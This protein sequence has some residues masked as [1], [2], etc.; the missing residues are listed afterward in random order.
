RTMRYHIFPS[1]TLFRSVER[2]EWS[3]GQVDQ[4]R[5]ERHVDERDRDR[6]PGSVE[7]A[8]QQPDQ[9]EPGQAAGGEGKD[10]LGGRAG[11]PA[12]VRRSEEHTSELQSLAYLV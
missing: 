7:V 8:D 9:E 4:R 11:Q 1:P 12:A 2:A 3:A 6:D 5:D 10:E